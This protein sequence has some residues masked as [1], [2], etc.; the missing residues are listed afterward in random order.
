MG[1]KVVETFIGC[2]VEGF[3]ALVD[4]FE[5]PRFKEKGQILIYLRRV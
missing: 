5:E 3:P 1:L 2:F 4:G